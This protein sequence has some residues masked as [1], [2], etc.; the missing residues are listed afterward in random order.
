[1]SGDRFLS[2]WSKRK[3]QGRGRATKKTSAPASAAAVAETLSPDDEIPSDTLIETPT[4]APLVKT[5][6]TPTGDGADA[7]EEAEMSPEELDAK[8]EELGL[9]SLQSLGPGSDF[10]PFMSGN[11]PKQLRNLALRKLWGSNPVLA[12]LDGLVDYGEDFTDAA[13]VVKNMQTAYQVGRG[14]FRDEEPETEE[15]IDTVATDDT[16]ET[17][18]SDPPDSE[19]EDAGAAEPDDTSENDGAEDE[20]V[21]S[22]DA[23]ITLRNAI[24]KT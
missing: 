8:A 24:P 1:M 7:G 18:P 23:D 17:A 16:A 10:K 19:T 14:Y 2:R 12:N 5:E 11:V 13:L 21:A 4:D 15:E 20:S 3:A 6:A 22:E 9:P